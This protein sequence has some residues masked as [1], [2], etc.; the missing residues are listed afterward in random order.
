MTFKRRREPHRS[1]AANV[2]KRV[3]AELQL[4]HPTE[5]SIDDIAFMRNALVD[6]VD[7]LGARANAVRF[8]GG[9]TII[10]VRRD[11]SSE[12]RRFAVAHELGHLE[13]HPNTS[14]LGLCT[15]DDMTSAYRESGH[16]QE[17]NAFAAE[18]LMPESLFGRGCDVPRVSWQPVER[19]ATAFEVSLTSAAMRF[20]ELCPERVALVCSKDKRILWSWRGPDFGKRIERGREL[21]TYSLAI[22]FW[23]KGSV[24]KGPETVSASAWIDGASD[25][26]ELVEH[27]IAFNS[28]GWVLSLLWIKPDADW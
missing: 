11:L 4:K 18:L 26:A 24:P 14:Y 2:A 15:D 1:F 10:S 3:F 20:V 22:D 7:G 23:E 5:I 17:A 8:G 13:V 25:N 28:I 12:A 19:L 27:A 16:E 21:D 6:D 9:R